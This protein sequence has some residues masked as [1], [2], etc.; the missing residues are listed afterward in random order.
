MTRRRAV[1]M[2]VLTA[3]AA[4]LTACSPGSGPSG[5]GPSG[6]GP[7]QE[8]PAPLA[9]TT[10]EPA[11]ANPSASSVLVCS[12]EARE[13]I[14]EALGVAPTAIDPPTWAD[15]VYSCRYRYP[16]GSFTL[17]VKELSSVAETTAYMDALAQRLGSTR[18]EDGLGEGAFVTT[19]GSVV[20]RKDFKVLLVDDTDLPPG[21]GSPPITPP[22]TALLVARTIIGCWTGA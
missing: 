21:L 2:A 5:S 11:G 9:P 7:S 14:T 3:V 22:Q 4:L 13:D 10:A 19:N 1:G 16:A 20:V 6:S 17:S 15:H 8:V 18:T 12:D